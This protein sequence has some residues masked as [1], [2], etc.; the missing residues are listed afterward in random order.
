M[1]KAMAGNTLIIGIT[2]G[3]VE[4]MKD[5]KPVKFSLAEMGLDGSRVK[6]VVV[7]YGKDEQALFNQIKPGVDPLK[8]IFHS[9]QAEN[10]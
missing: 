1:L 8:T 5:D 4:R 2:E 3:N 10:N 7:F 9:N 6:E